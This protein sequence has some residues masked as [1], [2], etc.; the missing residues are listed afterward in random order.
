MGRARISARQGVHDLCHRGM[1]GSAREAWRYAQINVTEVD[2]KTSGNRTLQPRYMRPFLRS[3]SR[4]SPSRLEYTS[5]EIS[6]T[7]SLRYCD[8]DR[9]FQTCSTHRLQALAPFGRSFRSLDDQILFLL[10]SLRLKSGALLPAFT[11]D[12]RIRASD[13]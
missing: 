5:P 11:K 12:K 1:L 10:H 8:I 2:R 4:C 13:L 6:H 7:N 3:F 9:Q